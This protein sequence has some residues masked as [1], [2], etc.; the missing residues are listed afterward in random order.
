MLKGVQ[1]VENTSSQG[2]QT[3]LFEFGLTLPMYCSVSCWTGS[4]VFFFMHRCSE[5]AF[6]I[7]SYQ[8]RR[9]EDFRLKGR[10]HAHRSTVT[11][12]CASVLISVQ[13]LALEQNAQGV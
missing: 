13:R 3:S 2:D 5:A 1:Q 8:L 7:P 6:R 11:L 9:G 12:G 4:F 10:G